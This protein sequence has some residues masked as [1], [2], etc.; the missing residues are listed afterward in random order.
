MEIK[1]NPETIIGKLVYL[2]LLIIL[3]LIMLCACEG[4]P[5]ANSAVADASEPTNEDRAKV[6]TKYIQDTLTV[7]KSCWYPSSADS[8]KDSL[9]VEGK[10]Y[11]VSSRSR[12]RLVPEPET[13]GDVEAEGPV[14]LDD[15]SFYSDSKDGTEMIYAL[16]RCAGR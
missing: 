14:T 1:A 7:F 6:N 12:Y 11:T 3:P 16:N 5:A 9:V 8:T 13:F 4:T 10:R 2:A 15:V